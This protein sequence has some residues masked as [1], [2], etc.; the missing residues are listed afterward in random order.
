MPAITKFL[1]RHSSSPCQGAPPPLPRPSLQPVSMSAEAF[2]KLNEFPLKLVVLAVQ[3]TPPKCLFGGR[4][5][6]ERRASQPNRVM[7]Q[8]RR[9][10]SSLHP[11]SALLRVCFAVSPLRETTADRGWLCRDAAGFGP[12]RGQSRLSLATDASALSMH[13]LIIAVHNEASGEGK[14]LISVHSEV[15]LWLQ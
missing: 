2:S 10:A 15:L 11:R 6:A 5:L 13:R 3:S 8:P 1:L 7:R 4:W 12:A 9:G 14:G